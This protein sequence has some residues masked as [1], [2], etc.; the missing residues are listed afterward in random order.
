LIAFG[1][2]FVL[3]WWAAGWSFFAK[4]REQLWIGAGAVTFIIGL[5][6]GLARSGILGWR[7][8][9]RAKVLKARHPDQPWFA[10]SPWDPRGTDDQTAFGAVSLLVVAFVFLIMAPFNIMWRYA[11]DPTREVGERF[12]VAGMLFIPNFFIYLVIKG[13][14]MVVKE[15]RRFG[16]AH[17]AFDPF[18]FFLGETLAARVTA[19]VFAGQEDVVAILRCIDERTVSRR[20]KGG[21][22]VSILPYQVYEARQSFPGRFGGEDVPLTFALPAQ[23]ATELLRQP[24]RYWELE[25]R[26]RKKDDT[27][28]FTVPVYARG[29]T[30]SPPCSGTGCPPSGPRTAHGPRA[31]G[32]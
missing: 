22:R 25:I 12:L 10:D 2:V 21:R 9:A 32:P 8:A 29:G 27:V 3:G 24:P 5:G 16:R 17:L 1:L 15:R 6:V 28:V 23:P 20:S 31:T 19:K 4:G 30:G 11:L 26:G 18:P 14:W 13:V 7:R